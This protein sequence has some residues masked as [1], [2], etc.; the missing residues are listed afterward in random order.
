M[1]IN[2]LK[3]KR[4]NGAEKAIKAL[5]SPLLYARILAVAVAGAASS[6][7]AIQGSDYIEPPQFK[8]MDRYQ[9]NAMGNMV[10]PPIQTVAIGGELGLQHS[11]TPM[12]NAFNRLNS[13]DA[14][15][16]EYSG[17]IR[18]T[19]LGKNIA[20]W[21]R[22]FQEVA[23]LRASFLGQQAQFLVIR[24]SDNSY[25]FPS[26]TGTDFRYVP[27]GD[28]RHKLE[29]RT[30]GLVWTQPDGTEVFFITS[31]AT[32]STPPSAQSVKKIIYPNGFT[33]KVGSEVGL[34]VTT[35][36]GYGLKYEV[37][38]TDR[39]LDSSKLGRFFPSNSTVPPDTSAARS[40]FQSANPSYFTAVNTAI[41]ACRESSATPC[42]SKWPKAT[43]AWPAGM[44]R[45]LY[46]DKSTISVTNAAGARTDLTYQAFDA[47]QGNGA[48]CTPNKIIAPRL[49][50]I[51]YPGATEASVVY[52]YSNK[53]VQTQSQ[54]NPFLTTSMWGS[55]NS[56]SYTSPCDPKVIMSGMLSSAEGFL[57]NTTYSTGDLREYH[58]KSY[59]G[60]EFSV[61]ENTADRPGTLEKFTD[62][63]GE[64]T[65]YFEPAYRN[66]VVRE[67]SSKWPAKVYDYDA[68][69]N[70]TSITQGPTVTLAEYPATCTNPKTCNQPIWVKDR[71]GN[72]T[73]FTYHPE[74]GQVATVTSPANRQG[75]I[76]QTRYTY[77]K[78]FANYYH[79]D[80]VKR[81]SDEGIWLKTTESH[82]ANSNYTNDS[83]EGN[84]EVVTTYEYNH[85][86]LHMTAMIVRAKNHEGVIE[87]QRTCYEYDIYGNRISETA[88]KGTGT[89]CPAQ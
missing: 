57:G 31:D 38:K 68:R 80:G 4:V 15:R 41:D 75:K 84:D 8:M 64:R 1:K 87:E 7:Y 82:C 78:E 13:A 27:L 63:K 53:K 12:G 85:D 25:Q 52:S 62:K 72:K 33:I 44:P 11:I 58:G 40:G 59:G 81:K 46:I 76:A 74:S 30:D 29:R 86:N 17:G 49:V 83:C 10:A 54:A 55:S 39:P 37:D 56:H 14:Y 48:N 23:V 66:L 42:P 73:S 9:V 88:P 89:S 60:D 47:A 6:S 65:L 70:L 69:G 2:R 20:V 34:G 21:G 35:N 24:N 22:T 18:N 28:E 71:N 19:V 77:K 16:D 36:T 5:S 43:I 26:Y 51:K 45:A 3:N 79:R 61:E 50:E 32:N 67:T